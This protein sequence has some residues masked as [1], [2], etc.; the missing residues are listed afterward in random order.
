MIR[1]D[2]KPVLLGR[3]PIGKPKISVYSSAGGLLQTIQV[4]FS[5]G[6]RGSS[7]ADALCAPCLSQWDAPTRIVSLGWTLNESLVV[8]TQDGTYRLYALSTGATPP[9]YTQ[10]S[11]GSD[12]Q[13]SGVI[14]AKIYEEGMVALL[15]SLAFVEVKGWQKTS[16]EGGVGGKVTVLASAGLTEPPSCWCVISPE[17]SYTRG[18]EVLIGS[19]ATVLRLDE[20]EVQD[21]V[22]PNHWCPATWELTCAICSE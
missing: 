12:A 14:E 8:L 11:L 6:P 16:D 2:R 15:G 10:H 19:G 17:L 18:V 1:D 21:Q 3:H 13:E 5:A 7:L 4:R 9:S 22:R 20:I